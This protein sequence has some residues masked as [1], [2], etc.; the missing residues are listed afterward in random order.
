VSANSQ[1]VAPLEYFA[2]GFVKDVSIS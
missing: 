2:K 1:R